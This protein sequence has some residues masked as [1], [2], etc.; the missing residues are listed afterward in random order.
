[1][2]YVGGAE[3]P[4]EEGEAQGARRIRGVAET[5]GGRVPRTP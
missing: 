4:R 1:M 3:A 5:T 2:L